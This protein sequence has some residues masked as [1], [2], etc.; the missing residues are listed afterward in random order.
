MPSYSSPV[1]S[2]GIEPSV[3]GMPQ[4]PNF[5]FWRRCGLTWPGSTCRHAGLLRQATGLCRQDLDECVGYVRCDI[6][7]AGKYFLGRHAIRTVER[8]ICLAVHRYACALQAL[9]RQTVRGCENRSK[10]RLEIQYLWRGRPA[11]PTV[12]RQRTRRRQASILAVLYSVDTLSRLEDEN[13]VG[14][15]RPY[16]PAETAA[17]DGNERWIAPGLVILTDNKN[18]FASSGTEAEGGFEDI[19]DHCDRIRATQ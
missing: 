5:R 17:G 14:R 19:R 9:R 10:P 13:D 1:E 3:A 7:R 2:S 4:V 8:C 12:P 6:R 18:A 11:V 15:L 16:L